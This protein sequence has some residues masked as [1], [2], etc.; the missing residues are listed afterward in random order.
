MHTKYIKIFVYIFFAL[1][2][3]LSVEVSACTRPMVIVMDE[4]I[5]T[6]TNNSD[7]RI[8]G[9]TSL[10]S[11]F[12]VQASTG[13]SCFVGIELNPNLRIKQIEFVDG[14]GN[15]IFGGFERDSAVGKSL[16]S[17]YSAFVSKAPNAIPATAVSLRVEAVL[18]RS[19]SIQLPEITDLLSR[20]RVVTGNLD[21]QGAIGDHF[22]VTA[23]PRNGSLC[24]KVDASGNPACPP[25]NPRLELTTPAARSLIPSIRTTASEF[26]DG[27]CANPFVPCNCT[28]DG[29]QTPCGFVLWCL[30]IGACEPV[31]N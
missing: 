24:L 19:S 6:P 15:V 17:G 3:I 1:F 2:T 28:L 14:N 20:A 4:I 13:D 7:G 23:P 18:L 5:V 9:G 11:G 25:A 8:I 31:N 22:T 30:D 16:G 26:I 29:F 27:T 21:Q 10:A 12:V